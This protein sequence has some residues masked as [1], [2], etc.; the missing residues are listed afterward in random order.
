MEVY[1]KGYTPSTGGGD[2]PDRGLTECE[3]DC[4]ADIHCASGLVC[5]FRDEEDVPGCYGDTKGGWDYCIRQEVS[6]SIIRACV[7]RLY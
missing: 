1:N 6:D 4:D 2:P 5:Y 7:I 3:G